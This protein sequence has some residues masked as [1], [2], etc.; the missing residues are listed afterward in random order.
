MKGLKKIL[1][2]FFFVY[3]ILG[4]PLTYLVECF[5]KYSQIPHSFFRSSFKSKI[6]ISC[7]YLTFFI[8]FI[9]SVCLPI[10]L[11]NFFSL[12]D[13]Y[14]KYLVFFTCMFILSCDFFIVP[15]FFQWLFGND[16]QKRKK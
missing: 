16:A 13:R 4:F 9:L 6:R 5:N 2:A 15:K 14:A 8:G 11:Q 1:Y 3:G 12:H 10:E 7:E